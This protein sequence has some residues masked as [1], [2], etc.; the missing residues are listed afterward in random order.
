MQIPQ[1]LL[2]LAAEQQGLIRR[3]QALRF[4]S[5]P[6]IARLIGPD[7]RWQPVLR[8]VYATSTGPLTESQRLRAAQMYAGNRALVTGV[9]ALRQFGFR[10]LPAEELIDV[11]IA[12]SESRHS[13][14][15]VR[16]QRTIWLPG[17]ESIHDDVR[18]APRARAVMDACRRSR[19]LDECRA[20]MAEAVQ[21]HWI[22]PADL[23]RELDAGPIAWS[24]RARRALTHILEG[25]QAVSEC[26]FVGAVLPSTLLPR[27]HF[28]CTLLTFDGEFLCR[29]DAYAADVGLAAE[30]Q[31]VEHHLY[32]QAQEADMQRRLA[33]GRHGVQ[34]I[35]F[36]PSRIRRDPAG[37]RADMEATYLVRKEQGVVPRVRLA[38]RREC[39]ARKAS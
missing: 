7:G 14:S 12:S 21:R 38:C 34:V 18:F 1:Q 4:L 10:S 33:Y 37:V 30:V 22:M 3:S 15:F 16:V 5:E 2:V 35:E 11:L 9:A 28:N 24:G 17:P 39:R 19:S 31:S 8:G 26:D 20:L 13:H 6:R 25:A 32:P 23:Q 36:R 27:L 29:P